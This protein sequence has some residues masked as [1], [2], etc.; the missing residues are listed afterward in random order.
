MRGERAWFGMDIVVE[1]IQSEISD[2]SESPTVTEGISVAPVKGL[3][4]DGKGV[5]IQGRELLMRKG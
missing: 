1:P 5:E 3:D 4:L 2:S